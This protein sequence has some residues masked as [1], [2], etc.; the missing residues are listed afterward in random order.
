MPSFSNSAL[1]LLRRLLGSPTRSAG[2]YAGEPTALDGA[3]AVAVTEAAISELAGLGA[4][5]PAD[6]AEFAWRGEQ[7]RHGRNL[8]GGALGGLGAEGARGALASALGAA[9]GGSRATAFL[10]SVDLAAALDQLRAA[11]GRRAPLVVHLAN[12][13]LPGPAQSFGSG[14]ETLHMACSTG[15]FVLVAA[16]VQEAV[17]FSLVARRVAEETLT[18]GLVAMDGEQTALAMQEVRLAPRALIDRLVGRPDDRVDAPDAA[19]RLIFGE[20]RRRLPRLQDP[21]HPVLLGAP[22]GTESWGLA[23]ASGAV[24]GGAVAAA[25]DCAMADLA[26]ETGRRHTAVSAYRT[27]DASLV[28]IALGAA[29]ETAEA[30]AEAMR[31]RERLK[32]G[33]I[34]VRRLD[35]FPADALLGH[36]KAGQQVLV[37]ERLDAPLDREPPLLG[38]LRAALHRAAA[39]TTRELSDLRL[40]QPQAVVY[41]LGGLPLRGADLA[42]L[43]LAAKRRQPIPRY[44]GVDFAPAASQFPKRQILLDRLRRDREGLGTLG[45]RGPRPGPDLRP[46]GALTLAIHR[47][48]GQRGEGLA[49]E[50]AAF[51]LAL[52]GS[53]LRSRPALP[54][55]PWGSYCVDRLTTGPAELRDPGADPPVDLAVLTLDPAMRGSDPLL[56]LGPDGALLIF[57]P[58]EDG[59]LWPLLDPGLQRALRRQETAL[60]ALTPPAGD[61]EAA[62]LGAICAV[63]L[64]RGWLD[65]TARRVQS[66][67]ETHQAERPTRTTDDFAA[68]LAGTRRV[69]YRQLP[70]APCP[71]EPADDQAPAMVRALGHGDDRYDSLP[72]FWDQV[73]VLYRTGT[74]TELTPDPYLALG[75]IPPLSSAFRD[76]SGQRSVMPVLDLRLCTG[77]GQCWTGCPD[78]AIGAAALTPRAV[79][80][81][82]I[83][84]AK[85]T[86]LQPLAGKLAERM[87]QQCAK[88]DGAPAESLGELLDASLDW[89]KSKMPLPAE[90]KEAV[91][92]AAQRLKETVGALPVAVTDTLL[93]TPETSAPGSGRL[94]F[95]ALE[96]A[97]C[98]GCGLCVRLCTPGAL[99][100]AHQHREQVEP[101]RAVRQAWERLP[102]TSAETIALAARSDMGALPALLLSRRASAGMIGGD[103]AESGSGARLAL[104]LAL[105]AAS[106]HQAP[107]RA[108]LVRRVAETRERIAGLIRGILA[109]A[110]PADDLDTL[111]RGLA[112]VETRQTDLGTFV[113]LAEGQIGSALDAERLKRLVELARQL[114]DYEERL[115]QGRQ[116]LGRASVSLVLSPEDPAGLAG[117][118]PQNAFRIPVTLDP[119]GDGP[120]LAAGLLE[121]QLRQATVGLALLRKAR[122]ELEKPADARRRW[123]ELDALGWHDLSADERAS[124]PMLLLVGGARMLA[125]RGLSQL[126]WLLGGDLPV[127]VMVLSELDLGLTDRAGVDSL[128]AALPDPGIELALLALSQRRVCVAQTSIGA[129]EH[130][131][132]SL[133]TALSAPGPA[134]V[135]VHAPSP[136]RHG[137]ATDRTLDQAR[138]AVETRT[139]P[140]FV[141]DP[142]AEGVFGA[143]LD[144]EGNPAPQATWLSAAGGGPMTPADWAATETRFADYLTPLAEDAPKPI[145]LAAYLALQPEHRPGQTPFVTVERPDRDPVRYAVAPELIPVC[146]ARK[147]SWRALQE[148][149]GLVTPFTA[150]VQEAAEASVAAAHQAEL[151]EQAARYEQRIAELRETFQQEM[152]QDIRERLMRLA[153]YHRPSNDQPR[154]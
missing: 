26:R 134:L 41:G 109:D 52:Q 35:P 94:L 87:A 92:L 50:A 76:I 154:H 46:A 70:D 152:R 133:D 82:A 19:Q 112:S 61:L 45:L 135:H 14:H 58:A 128:P 18:P 83:G 103:G 143:R 60:Y 102:E 20:R 49:A 117:A 75:A 40:L 113:G 48:S 67:W 73:G 79:I 131:L 125:G 121:A 10:S 77:C 130:L 28:L 2:P 34:G 142:R 32:V 101:A 57:G 22:H 93:R 141:Y 106:A 144:L 6:T 25:L 16:N 86:A 3:T 21:E 95:I 132:R 129:P 114:A 72:R 96:S 23:A 69:D 31:Q 150:R 5:F 68:G 30:A 78:S 62:L 119:T 24:F 97:A 8:L 138:L 55:Q 153:G 9:L 81:T 17:D 54:S 111:A 53:G 88:M 13:A 44:L 38:A 90:R 27:E 149:A 37:L 116:G 51:L 145:R 42:A 100:M 15:C 139:L 65:S 33:V 115:T 104:R 89:L 85:A 126:V 66:A 110:L 39:E 140:L 7:R 47:R 124:C 136:A 63:L 91:T 74:T 99:S 64:D 120:Q 12:R 71:P 59:L 151:A 108:A 105:A 80:D 11:A 43:C 84:T 118:F 146:E 36:L 29:V 4:S 127:K 98:K 122:L 123:S 1:R 148:L 56:D 107:A 137:F 147:A